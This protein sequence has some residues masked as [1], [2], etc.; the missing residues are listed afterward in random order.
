M[1][2]TQKSD[3]TRVNRPQLQ[4]TVE[5][6]LQPGQI[7]LPNG[8]IINTKQEVVSPDSKEAAP[9]KQIRKQK[10]TR[11]HEKQK[12]KERQ[13]FTIHGLMAPWQLISP[14]HIIG[15]V[16]SDKPFMDAY[17]GEAQS[18]TGN[19]AADLAIDLVT[20]AIL[21]KSGIRTFGIINNLK[22]QNIRNHL[23]VAKP[24]IGYDGIQPAV[25]RWAKGILSGKEADIDNPWWFTEEYADQLATYAP[26]DYMFHPEKMDTWV[27]HA[28]EARAD[29]WRMYN[30]I[31]Q[32]YNTF[33]PNPRH[34]GSFTDNKGIENLA[35][36][37]EQLANTP[38]KDFINSSGGN[39]G[40]P[41]IKILDRQL[42]GNTERAFGVTTT[43]DRF[44]LHPFRSGVHTFRNRYVKPI[45]EKYVSDPL[46]HTAYNVEKISNLFKYNNKEINAW[47]AKNKNNPS[48][49][50]M[51]SPDMFPET[52][53]KRKIGN[54][55]ESVS[56]KIQNSA[57]MPEFKFL[58]PLEDKLANFEVSDLTGGKPFLVQYDIPWT[59]TRS[60][61][62]DL[63]LQVNYEPG[64]VP[65]SEY[66]LPSRVIMYK[67][68]LSDFSENYI[69]DNFNYKNFS[70]VNLIKNSTH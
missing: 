34:P 67:H 54:A 2:F 61:T 68:G 69:R 55:L 27:Q 52:G 37:D 17:L 28:L 50:D 11:I 40:I 3:N 18:A 44:D 35:F 4:Y 47:L 41:E 5:R 23:Y 36:I 57:K 48:A 30:K 58:K 45:W 31:P 42:N 12:E 20:P 43:S 21:A 38:Q 14:S 10:L 13:N 9:I 63:N 51:F 65:S 26:F 33:T 46:Y 64:F 16:N 70:N 8:Q 62:D 59:R 49:M 53:L 56:N 15:S 25:K 22:P 66:I 29:A 7:K 60:I 19:V 24:P 32:K 6:K 39:V 1:P